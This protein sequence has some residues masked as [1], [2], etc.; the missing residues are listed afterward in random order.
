MLNPAI[1]LSA[2]EGPPDHDCKEVMEK[3]YFS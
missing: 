2:E 1:F 3:V